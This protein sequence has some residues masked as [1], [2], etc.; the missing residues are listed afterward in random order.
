MMTTGHDVIVVG[1]GP[2]GVAAASRSADLGARTALVTRDRVGGMA[3]HDGPVPVRTMAYAARLARETKQF[4]EYGI[5]IG[6]PSVD[7]PALVDR[8]GEVVAQYDKVAGRVEYL[9]EHGVDVFEDSG[10]ASFVDPHTIECAGGRRF[11]GAKVVLCTGGR[12]KRLPIPGFEHTSTHTD[13]WRLT[14][15]PAS[16][17]VVGSGAT[18]AQVASIFN[19]LGT[20][21]TLMEVGSRIVPTEDEDVSAAVRGAFEEHGMRVLEG[22]EGIT[23]FEP[24]GAGVRTRF[25]HGGADREVVTD[26]V[27]MAV[28]WSAGA[29]ELC[30]PAAGV[31]TDGRGFVEVDGYLRTSAGHIFAAGDVCGQWMLVPTAYRAGYYAASNAVEGPRHLMENELIP[32][33]SF[34]DPEYAQIGLTESAARDDHD[35]VVSTIDFADFSRSI[36]D[37]RRRGFCKL[38][39]DRDTRQILGCHVVGERAVDTVQLVTA[40]MA[41]GLTVD[42]LADLPLSFPTYGAI[43]GWAAY[44][45][46]KQ[47]GMDRDRPYWMAGQISPGQLRS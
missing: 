12:P 6:P 16:M 43:V 4:A 17:V 32:F 25:R 10:T 15:L 27:V 9:S 21:V 47:L 34:T 38:I 28:G 20:T 11:T 31:A 1:G 8:V 13:A 39:A 42:R 5:V 2:A 22:I 41:A 26:L 23:G 44:D 46:V 19:A 3:A 45:I 18:G 35:V 40:G 14:A 37:G 36:I 29:D 30:L 7:Y 24:A 33:G